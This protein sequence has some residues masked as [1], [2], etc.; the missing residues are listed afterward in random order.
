VSIIKNAFDRGRGARFET[1]FQ[2]WI[3]QE[4]AA[5]AD[6]H[7][8]AGY[9]AFSVSPGH[10]KPLENYIADRETHHRKESFQDEYR[11]LCKKYGVALDERYV[12]D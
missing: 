11:R 5:L 4:Y 6:F 12:W 9:G 8:Q 10:V 3:K 1:G 2:Q 7:W